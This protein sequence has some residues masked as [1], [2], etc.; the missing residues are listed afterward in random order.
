MAEVSV[1][2]LSEQIGA[3]VRTRQE[4]RAS[5]APREALESNRVALARAQQQ[6]AHLLIER[7]LP[8]AS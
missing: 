3:L 8:R 2:S 1:E 5:G 6:M 7:Y 4:L